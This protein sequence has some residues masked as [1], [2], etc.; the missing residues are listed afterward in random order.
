VTLVIPTQ[1]RIVGYGSTGGSSNNKRSKIG[2]CVTPSFPNKTTVVSQIK[3]N[4]NPKLEEISVNTIK[5]LN[6]DQIKHSPPSKKHKKGKVTAVVALAKYNHAR[7]HKSSK[8]ATKE[9]LIWVLLDSGSDGDLLFQKKG[10][11]NTSP[12]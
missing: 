9:R 1:N 7:H 11:S 6:S 2:L 8:M 3:T 4:K 10:K 5:N 12:T